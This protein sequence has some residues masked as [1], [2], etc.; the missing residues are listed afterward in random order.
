MLLLFALYFKLCLE[1]CGGWQLVRVIRCGIWV[2][3]FSAQELVVPS[4][5]TLTYIEYTSNVL[6]A[7]HIDI[8][9]LV[10]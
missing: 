1:R 6:E 10:A 3:I 5:F 2:Y 9:V 7:A 8:E 4:Q